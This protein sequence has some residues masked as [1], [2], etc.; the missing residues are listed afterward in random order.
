MEWKV[1]R[2]G[3]RR[4]PVADRDVKWLSNHCIR[5]P[6]TVGYSVVLDLTGHEASLKY[7]RVTA[8]GREPMEL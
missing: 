2:P 1:R 4:G 8:A 6:H 3:M 7:T 5:N